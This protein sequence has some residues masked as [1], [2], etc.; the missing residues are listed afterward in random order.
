[1]G[2]LGVQIRGKN[3]TKATGKAQQKAKKKQHFAY[4]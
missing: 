3:T 4:G 2:R 1:M